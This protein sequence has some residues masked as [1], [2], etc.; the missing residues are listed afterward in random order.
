LDDA[1]MIIGIF[2]PFGKITWPHLRCYY[3]LPFGR[4][5]DRL[6]GAS[7]RAAEWYF[8]FSYFVFTLAE[9]KNEIH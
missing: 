3:S 8:I 4:P 9:R 7:G 6:R 2:C 5:F 1:M